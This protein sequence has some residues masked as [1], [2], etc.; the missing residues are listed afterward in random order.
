M[1]KKPLRAELDRRM[2]EHERNPGSA[3]PW[4]Q[5]RARLRSGVQETRPESNVAIMALAWILANITGL[6]A[7][8]RTAIVIECGLQN[9][10]LAIF[11]AATLLGSTTMMAPGGVY[12]SIFGTAGV[13]VWFVLKQIVSR[14]RADS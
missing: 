13:I 2:A 1:P 12:S 14:A 5:V 3:I 7:R 6:T 4:D 8:Q 9:G 10:T 11:V